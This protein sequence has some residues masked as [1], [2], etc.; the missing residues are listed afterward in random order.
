MLKS[1]VLKETD[2]RGES[3][4][5][6][7]QDNAQVIKLSFIGVIKISIINLEYRIKDSKDSENYSFISKLINYLQEDNEV[8]I[9]SK[10]STNQI[11]FNR[12]GIILSVAQYLIAEAEDCLFLKFNRTQV[13][14]DIFLTIEIQEILNEVKGVVE[15]SIE[16]EKFPK[17]FLFLKEK[18]N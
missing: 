16:K 12:K 6:V 7:Y 13:Q 10:K 9:D 5:L 14:N 11:Y 3:L 1:L 2:N 18:L 15:I 17:T 8:W 4:L